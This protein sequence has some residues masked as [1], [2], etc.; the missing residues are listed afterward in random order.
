MAMFF[1]M[2]NTS[3]RVNSFVLYNPYC[4]IIRLNRLAYIKTWQSLSQQLSFI[5]NWKESI[6]LYIVDLPTRVLDD[7]LTARKT[8]VYCPFHLKSKN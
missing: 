7:I 4:D 8:C 5:V 3:A 6:M 1:A 2:G